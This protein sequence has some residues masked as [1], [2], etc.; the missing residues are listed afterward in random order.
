MSNSHNM[1]QLFYAT[2][3]PCWY[4]QA[5][6]KISKRLRRW[7]LAKP[8]S[9]IW[10]LSISLNKFRRAFKSGKVKSIFKKGRET[11]VSNYRPISLL[12]IL[13]KFIEKVVHEQ[14]TK[15][16]ND[17]NIFYKYQFGFR[18]N[19]STDL[20]LSFLIDKI[21]KGSDTEMYTGMI[22]TDLQ[23]AFDATNRKILL[24]KLLPTG[25]SKNKSGWYESYLAERHFTVDVANQVPKVAN[26][27]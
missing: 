13:S 18:S 1:Q 21:L 17:T 15:F 7:I 8:V 9:D 14:T 10:N 12:S 19:G 5:S 2:P 3:Y 24:D 27:S 6:W 4:W 23:K 22:L 25:F 26:I 20:F 16:L 11:N